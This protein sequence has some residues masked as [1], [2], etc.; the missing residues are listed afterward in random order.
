MALFGWCLPD[1]D[2]PQH[3]KCTASFDSTTCHCMCHVDMVLFTKEYN[4]KNNKK[5]IETTSKKRAP[6]RA[7][8]SVPNAKTTS[9][10]SGVRSTTTATASR[11]ASKP[12]RDSE[13]T[14]ESWQSTSS[15]L[16]DIVHSANLKS[17][18]LM[19]EQRLL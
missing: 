17:E 1:M 14:E 6:N 10:G 7:K 11:K 9:A 18:Q 12:T 16:T 19:N 8:P 5:T 4:A 13:V 2:I 3:S 15:M